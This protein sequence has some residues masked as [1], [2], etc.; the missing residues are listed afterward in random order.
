V[1]AT[2]GSDATPI[3]TVTWIGVPAP[4]TAARQR[5]ATWTAAPVSV[6]GSSTAELLTADAAHHVV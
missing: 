3:E 5:S 2:V 1:V 6:R 4:P